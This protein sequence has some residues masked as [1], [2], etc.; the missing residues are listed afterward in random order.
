MPML[1]PS[2]SDFTSFVKATAQYVPSGGTKKASKSAAGA[3]T[4]P[5]S[6]GAVVRTSRVGALVSPTTTNAIINGLV[7]APAMARIIRSG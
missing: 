2:G 4:A 1:R 7:S 6:L 5:A 3:V